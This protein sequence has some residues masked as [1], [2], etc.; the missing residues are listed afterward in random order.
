MTRKVA[1]VGAG[2]S[3]VTTAYELAS[4][5]FQVQVF[6]RGGSVAEQASF[7]SSSVLQPHLNGLPEAP[8]AAPL[9]HRLQRWRRRH[10]V[11][12]GHAAWAALSLFSGDRT[13]TLRRDLAIDDE[14]ASGLLVAL[15]DTKSYAATESA[16][17][18]W[19]TAGIPASLLDGPQ[20]RALEPGLNAETPLMGAL[21]L[22]GGAGNPRLFAQ[23][24]RHVAQRRGVEFRFHTTVRSLREESGRWCLVHEH[25]PPAE[26]P[27]RSAPRDAGDTLPQALGPQD[28]PFDAVVL[29]NGLDAQRLMARPLPLMAQ[30]EASVTA[31][32]RMLEAHPDLGPKAAWLDPSR[33]VAIARIGQRVRITGGLTVTT[34]KSSTTLPDAMFE[35]LHQALQAWFPGS[36]LHQQVQQGVSRRAIAADHLPLLGPTGTPGLWLNLPVGGHGW[37]L[38]CGSA[39]VL[40]QQIAGEAPTV[41]VTAL[42]PQRLA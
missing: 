26:P 33:G 41:D 40:A 12:A 1:V 5:G 34:P 21:R 14:P 23:Q 6:E 20:A 9:G 24:L 37:S 10:R 36:V 38:A 35:Q 2:L 28:E 19:Q 22:E 42:S 4:L 31:P 8:S 16:L 39:R 32:L 17:A 15:T 18:G 13:T 7:A 29:C 25:T 27:A 11:E 3:G 30:L